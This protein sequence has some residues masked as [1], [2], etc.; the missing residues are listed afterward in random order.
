VIL[1]SVLL[2]VISS[3][4]MAWL[5]GSKQAGRQARENEQQQKSQQESCVCVCVCVHV[6]V[7]A[8]MVVREA[9]HKSDYGIMFWLLKANMLLLVVV[10]G[11]EM[12]I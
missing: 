5:L 12:C 9:Q 6:C 10:V 1:S 3:W 2:F 11:R 4:L 7:A 8:A